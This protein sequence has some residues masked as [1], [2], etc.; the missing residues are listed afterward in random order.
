MSKRDTRALFRKSVFER[1]GYRCVVCGRHWHPEDVPPE[2][3]RINAHHITNRNLMPNGG[4][5][6]ENGVTVCEG[7]CHMLVERGDAPGY[8]PADLYHK[9]GTDWREA[10]RK[11]EE[12]S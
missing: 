8:T 4:Y 7:R 9:I 6:A 1:D 3:K 5:V 11:A 12:L 2:L 10:A